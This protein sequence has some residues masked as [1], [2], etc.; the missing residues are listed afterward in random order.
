MQAIYETKQELAWATEQGNHEAALQL[1]EKR[2]QLEDY[3]AKIS[4]RNGQVRLAGETNERTRK[5]VQKEIRR[6]LKRIETTA[7]LLATY[8]KGQI[9]TGTTCFF[10]KDPSI[11]WQVYYSNK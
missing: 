7:P 3:C 4:N 11:D 10:R 1:R 8:L 2:E 9:G 6:T 5:A